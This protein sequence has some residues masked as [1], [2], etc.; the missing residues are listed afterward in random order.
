MLVTAYSQLPCPTA[1]NPIATGD[2]TDGFY[3]VVDPSSGW[4]AE[5]RSARARTWSDSQPG[6]GGCRVRCRPVSL[7]RSLPLDLATTNT[8]SRALQPHHSVRLPH[9]RLRQRQ[10]TPFSL[11][12]MSAIRLTSSLRA[13]TRQAALVSRRGYAD[14]ADGKLKLS[15]VLPHQVG[16]KEGMGWGRG[17]NGGEEGKRGDERKGGS[18]VRAQCPC[19]CHRWKTCARARKTRADV[20]QNVER[21]LMPAS[22]APNLPLNARAPATAY[23]RAF[24]P[25]PHPRAPVPDHNP[26]QSY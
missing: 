6:L 23:A 4:L 20:V 16:V 7:A 15:L 14:V 3:H 21:A 17:G 25:P 5:C 19:H 2:F 24:P 10:L 9:P 18:G 12:K 26:G 11:H 1:K 13:A 8:S 22:R